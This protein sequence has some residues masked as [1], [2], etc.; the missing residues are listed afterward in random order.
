MGERERWEREG[1]REKGV[2]TENVGEGEMLR[3]KHAG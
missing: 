1:R 3:E 2:K